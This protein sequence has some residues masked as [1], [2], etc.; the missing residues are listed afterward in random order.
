M[1][2]SRYSS[3]L[4]AISFCIVSSLFWI[5]KGIAQS[6][7]D[8]HSQHHAVSSPKKRRKVNHGAHPTASVYGHHKRPAK[9]LKDRVPL[10]V[11]HSAYREAH[12]E[13]SQ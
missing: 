9:R 8:Q 7:A 10:K 2:M 11:E 13:E 6:Q 4:I 3:A 5:P 12:P 1:Q